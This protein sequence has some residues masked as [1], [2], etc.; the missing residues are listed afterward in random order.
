MDLEEGRRLVAASGTRDATIAVTTRALSTGLAR[1]AVS[2][3]RALGYRARLDVV[4]DDAYFGQLA[5]A[6]FQAAVLAWQAD[7][8]SAGSWIEPQFS[9]E[10]V[11]LGSNSTR[12]CDQVVER[13]IRR[14]L[15]L[16]QTDPCAAN[17]VWARVDRM[18]TDRAPI[19]TLVY[20]QFPY[21]IAERI[22]NYQYHP[23]WEVLLDQLWV[24]S[25]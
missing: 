11:A 8:P 25:S 18:I 17:D 15:A 4:D 7:Y 19:V 1:L 16:Q 9:C 14:R 10:A 21:L 23:V 3:L 20:G 2:A 12:F 6:R 22:G 5:A 24:R 13:A